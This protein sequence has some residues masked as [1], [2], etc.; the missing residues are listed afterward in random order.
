MASCLSSFVVVLVAI[1]LP[2][3]AHRNKHYYCMM[4]ASIRIIHG[5][6]LT[7]A[8]STKAN[9]ESV[10]SHTNITINTMS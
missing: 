3:Y 8:K 9:H 4:I 7:D 1:F 2:A 5:K 10:E 6:Y